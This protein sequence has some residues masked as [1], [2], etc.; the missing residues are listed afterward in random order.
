MHSTI[1]MSRTT[2][3]LIDSDLGQVLI[4]QP[5]LGQGNRLE[6]DCKRAKKT[7]VYLFLDTILIA[8]DNKSTSGVIMYTFL[9][10]SDTT[11]FGKFEIAA[12]DAVAISKE[13]K[14]DRTVWICFAD[15]I[16]ANR[17][18]DAPQV[19]LYCKVILHKCG[20]FEFIYIG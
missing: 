5:A 12:L 19:D 1:F 13:V 11:A 3:F 16:V 20:D 14:D 4:V 9:D 18:D 2:F 8:S 10:F 17:D 6:G 15:Q 7:L